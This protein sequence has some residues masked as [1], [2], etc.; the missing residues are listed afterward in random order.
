MLNGT[1][2]LTYRRYNVDLRAANVQELEPT[3][4]DPK[5]IESLS[6]MDSP[7]NMTVLHRLGVLAAQRDISSEHFPAV[8]D[9]KN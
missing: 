5:L 7:A 1:A 8:F 4:T 3:L 2:A 6:A 9:L